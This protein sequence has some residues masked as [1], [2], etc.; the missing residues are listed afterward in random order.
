MKRTTNLQVASLASESGS[1]RYDALISMLGF[2]SR[3]RHIARILSSRVDR[4]WVF[5][6]S[7]NQVLGYDDNAEFYNSIG[8]GPEPVGGFHEGLREHISALRS[9]MPLD[10]STGERVTPRIAVDI[11]SMDR[12]L[13]ANAV[14]AC[15]QEQD[16]PLVVD[17]LYSCALFD[18]GLVGSEGPVLVN[19]PVNGLEG[20]SS[21]PD[22]GIVCVVGLGFEGRLATAAI[23]TIEP[24]ATLAL[25]PRGED[26]RYEDVVRTANATLL[27]S[28]DVPPGEYNVNNVL[29]TVIDLDASVSGWSRRERVVLVPLGPKPFALAAILVGAAHPNNVTVWRLSADDGRQPEDRIA[30]GTVIGLSVSVSPASS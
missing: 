20:W 28:L 23:E 19:R 26:D 13:I 10:E 5:E 4:H 24:H 21:D 12:D 1:V 11:S 30:S 27:E 15:T 8:A 25:I 14:L 7:S 16:E 18:A 29:Q 9:T 2:E 3:A 6:Y 22:A 17:F